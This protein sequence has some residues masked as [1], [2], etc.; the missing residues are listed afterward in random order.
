MQGSTNQLRNPRALR[1]SPSA[2]QL[3]LRFIAAAATYIALLLWSYAYVV[4]PQFSYMKYDFFV[5][6]PTYLVIG[7]LL[8]L[9]PALWMPVHFTRASILANYLLYLLVCI[10]AIIVPLCTR[11]I[12][13]NVALPFSAM[14][15]FCF[16]MLG[17][18]QHLPL[19]TISRGA[20]SPPFFWTLATLTTLLFL[21]IIFQTFGFSLKIHAL[22]DVYDVRDEF[23]D[24]L[25]KGGPLAGY[26]VIWTAN[27]V[28]PFLFLYGVTRNRP[29]LI[30]VSIFLCILIFS[31]SGLKSVFFS[32]LYLI[33]LLA[34]LRI[35]KG[36]LFGRLAVGAGTGILLTS[37][38]NIY[39][40]N[41]VWSSL[42]VRRM[43]LT[44]GLLAGF[45]H[46]FFTKNPHLYL[47]QSIFRWFVE[48]P[49][50]VRVTNLIGEVY[51]NR[52][53]CS[54]NVNFIADG[55]SNFGYPGMIAITVLL[56]LVFWTYDSFAKDVD[57]TLAS[58]LLA[59]P[60]IALSNCALLTVLSTHGL[61]LTLLVAYFVPLSK[62]HFQ[63]RAGAQQISG[64]PPHALA[65]VRAAN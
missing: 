2:A 63:K 25:Q 23:V 13:P 8:A 36:S 33:M 51:L 34:A 39:T 37:L 57:I 56:G 6:D 12:E 24:D 65:R 17:S 15:A 32:L 22:L 46:D 53:Q 21:A 26:V 43:I 44:P 45:Y 61:G 19:M 41:I 64:S 29:I 35:R 30:P 28:S 7:I 62:I 52:A 5:D 27:V 54:A 16:A 4:S 40:G 60:V 42:F 3:R 55:F 20:M 48:N 1:R 31:V 11:S 18:S 49:Y 14:T 47:S 9:T 10:P 59:L 50:D 58:L 38:I